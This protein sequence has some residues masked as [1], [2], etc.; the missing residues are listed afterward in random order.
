MKLLF[1]S[2][3]V[4]FA[5][6]TSIGVNAHQQGVHSVHFNE[7][8]WMGTTESSNNEWIELYNSSDAP[9][10]ITGWRIKTID[11][12][13]DI[14][15]KGTISA[16]RFFLLERTDDNTTPALA[17]QIY[18]GSLNNSGERLQLFDN[19]G[20][21]VDDVNGWTTGNNEQKMTMALNENHLWQYGVVD[22][23]PNAP[24]QFFELAQTNTPNATPQETTEGDIIS[25][26]PVWVSVVVVFVVVGFIVVFVLP[27][28]H[29]RKQA[30]DKENN[31]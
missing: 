14:D 3:F 21:L 1:V 31:E 27:H 29:P 19:N 30:E 4:V 26:T 22:G 24:N 6:F 5:L 9:I 10:D 28:T 11:G 12:S 18:T 15:L 16:H 20:V 2:V 17:D 8:A 7:I 25:N 13:P 23:T